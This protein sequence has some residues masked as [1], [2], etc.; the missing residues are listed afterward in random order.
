M[1]ARRT[2]IFNH[3]AYSALR[4]C[5]Y[6]NIY[7]YASTIGMYDA[8]HIQSYSLLLSPETIQIYVYTYITHTYT[9]I[10]IYIIKLCV[11]INI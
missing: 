11:D 7:R 9:L 2:Y 8:I 4:P 5:E 1:S 10:Y 3:S 6:I